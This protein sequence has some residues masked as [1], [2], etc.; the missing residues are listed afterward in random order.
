MDYF[1]K[2][3]LLLVLFLISLVGCSSDE[4]SS[5]LSLVVTDFQP[6]Y[7]Q[8]ALKWK[9]ERPG[10]IT[11]ES[12][13]VY[14]TAT[15]DSGGF[16][17]WELIANLPSNETTFTDMDVP[18]N[19]QVTYYVR[20]YY[21]RNNDLQHEMLSMDA[22]PQVFLRDFPTFEQV[23]FQVKQDP[24]DPNFFHILDKNGTGY[25][26]KYS[27]SQK[28]ITASTTFTNG[29]RMNNRFHILNNEIYLADTAGKISRL[30]ANDYH[31]IATYNTVIS[32]NLNAFAVDGDRIYY[33]DENIWNYYT[34]STG[35]STNG[36]IVTQMDYAE[37][38]DSNR[39][40][41][42]F[43]QQ[44]SYGFNINGFSPANCNSSDCFPDYTIGPTNPGAIPVYKMD[45]NIFAWNPTK[46]KFITSYEGWVMDMA[47]LQ[48]EFKLNSITGK[49]YFQFA[50]DSAGNIY[51]SVQGEKKIHKFNSSYQL[52]ETITTK[53]YP[54]FLMITNDNLQ[55]IGAYG[56][57]DYWGFW[58]GNEFDFN[59][60][61]AVEAF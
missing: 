22:E 19:L 18:Y 6:S 42:L 55:V 58:Y 29:W 34:I 3:Y 1:K 8:V 41:F 20:I 54:L 13:H 49:Q 30:S 33:Q 28:A 21:T 24:L 44:G 15:N 51:A 38:M 48:P 14:R 61:C 5:N 53:L 17:N 36:H 12:L 26:K 7:N 2:T 4:G 35:V 11:I 39:F 50:Y 32:D 57:V 47:T 31:T 45:P 46:Q 60:K 52:I 56:D 37:T 9:L 25:L 16:L 40:L 10:G 59:V 23:P 43:A 27:A